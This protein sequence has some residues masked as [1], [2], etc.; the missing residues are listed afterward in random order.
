MPKKKWTS[1]QEKN[2]AMRV[3]F[4]VALLILGLKFYAYHI[5]GSTAILSDAAESVVH[6]FAVGFATFSM[7]YSQKPADENHLYGHD[8]ISF[9]S[10]GFEGAMIIVAA[11][12]IIYESLL[13]MADGFEIR[14]IGQGVV[15]IFLSLIINGILGFSLIKKGKKYKSFIL[16]ANGRHL[17]T[18]CWTSSSVV[19]ALLLVKFTGIVWFD[20]CIALLT[21][22]TILWTGSKLVKKSIH[23]L[24]DQVEPALHKQILA[25]IQNTT[26]ANGLT[27]HHLRHRFSGHKI[28]IEFHLLFPSD[29]TLQEAHEISS[30]IEASV[31]KELD[32]PVEIFTH[33]EP[34]ENHDSTHKKYGLLI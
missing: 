13:K 2:F 8:K 30:S 24:M 14:S 10:A 22:I 32:F 4:F 5:T 23:G 20:P 6:I 16:D 26:Q 34:L 9:F 12:F 21:A 17:L 28:L 11:A 18:D 19:F 15:F 31:K 29:I 1:R 7:W 25:K 3:S 33:L 27:F